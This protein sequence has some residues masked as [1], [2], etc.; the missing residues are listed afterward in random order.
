MPETLTAKELIAEGQGA[1]KEKRYS[2]AASSFEQAARA[3][4]ASGDS[5]GAAEAANN[6]SVAYLQAGSAADA[7]RLA[8]G[9]PAVFAA[10]GDIRRQGMALANQAA[11]LESLHRLPE[12]LETYQLA[13][14]LLKQAGEKELR[15]LVLEN[16]STLQLRT[17]NQLQALASMD[18]ALE[19]K[20]K[21]SIRERL[22]K[23]LLRV[24]FD[25]L[26]RK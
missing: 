14:E 22:L 17:G 2:E 16:I 5:P 25:F 26:N 13:S 20:G 15:A 9:T 10:A 1:Y 8:E 3:L 7:L 24:P 4:Q 23:K 21:L 18:T 19:H 11:A 12:A 6:S